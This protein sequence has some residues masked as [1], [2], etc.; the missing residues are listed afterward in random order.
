MWSRNRKLRAAGWSVFN[1]CKKVMC[2]SSQQISSERRQRRFPSDLPTSRQ[3]LHHVHV[4]VLFKALSSSV[5]SRWKWTSGATSSITVAVHLWFRHQPHFHVVISVLS[6]LYIVPAE[7]ATLC[8]AWW[9]ST[10]QDRRNLRNQWSE[11]VT[12]QRNVIALTRPWFL[13]T[14]V[15]VCCRFS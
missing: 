10:T 14:I 12:Q 15:Q 13:D 8:R 9:T 7:C 6:Y 3:I 2:G 5:A 4:R 1:I 11:L